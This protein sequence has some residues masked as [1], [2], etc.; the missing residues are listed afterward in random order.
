MPPCERLENSMIQKMKWGLI[1]VA[2]LFALGITLYPLISNHLAEENRSLV[3]TQ[4]TQEIE[5]LDESE[6][7]A[8]RAAAADYNAT[9]VAV[10]DQAF[11][12]EALLKASESYESL[13]NLH[14][15]GIMAY[16]EIPRISVNLPIYHGTGDDSLNRGIGHLLGSS[17]PVGGA[18]THCVLTGHSGL[19][20]EKMFSDLDLLEPG[21]IFFLHTLGE[22]LA[23]MVQETFTVLPEDT[24]RL[25]IEGQHD[26]CTLVTCTP[27]GINSHRL[28]VRGE[29]VEY[30]AAVDIVESEDFQPIEGSTW[31]DAYLRGVG[32]GLMGVLGIIVFFTATRLYTK[33][34]PRKRGKHETH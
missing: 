3:E 26:Y 22:T 12:R 24:S 30:Q 29:R 27:F 20:S 33:L 32:Y 23:Y 15:D 1:A 8:A 9:L 31:T 34:H 7:I 6:L 25:M 14:S 21:D 5:Q 11:S 16:V 2:I 13:L 17:L 4:Y 10:T 19:A 18:A 28:L